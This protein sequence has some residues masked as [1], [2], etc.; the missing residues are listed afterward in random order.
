M[1]IHGIWDDLRHWVLAVMKQ[2]GVIATGATVTVVLVFLEQ[3]RRPLLWVWLVALVVACFLVWRDE[4]RQ[5]LFTAEG[6]DTFM[7]IMRVHPPQMP[8]IRVV[9]HYELKHGRRYAC[10]CVAAL[11]DAGW[12][13]KIWWQPTSNLEMNR[14]GIWVCGEPIETRDLLIAAFQAVH[15]NARVEP[16]QRP[17]V[18]G[19]SGIDITIGQIRLPLA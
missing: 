16:P 9:Y 17:Y 8:Q 15:E 6:R 7:D 5:H 11:L 3:G 12:D 13:A 14:R 2:W 1:D 4:R 18:E 19:L 10:D